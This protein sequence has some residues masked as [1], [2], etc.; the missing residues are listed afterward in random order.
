MN[1]LI[2]R[3]TP[4]SSLWAPQ[5]LHSFLEANDASYWH[6]CSAPRAG[7]Q[8]FGDR[9]T[10][11]SPMSHVDFIPCKIFTGETLVRRFGTCLSPQ[12]LE[13]QDIRYI[14]NLIQI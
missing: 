5:L 6:L 13:L 1:G 12:Y 4:V 10:A 7:L 2:S 14:F 8:V 11:A 3:I 9:G